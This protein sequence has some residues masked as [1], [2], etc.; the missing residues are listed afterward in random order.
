MTWLRWVLLAAAAVLV[1]PSSAM[2]SGGGNSACCG[3]FGNA[4][5][6]G[7]Y[8]HFS[9]CIAN[10]TCGG[11]NHVP[12]TVTYFSGDRSCPSG[13]Y[14]CVATAG[15]LGSG[16]DCH[17]DSD[18]GGYSPAPT[19]CAGYKGNPQASTEFRGCCLPNEIRMPTA[20]QNASSEWV[21]GYGYKFK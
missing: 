3:Q 6:W 14:D 21:I 16:Y 1:Q 13:S 12:V 20:I 15:D 17:G 8:S 19:C 18:C 11:G 5:P 10:A 4:G 9:L 7:G 2:S